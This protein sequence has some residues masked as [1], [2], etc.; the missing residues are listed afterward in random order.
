MVIV[1]SN[2]YT[3]FYKTKL[4]ITNISNSSVSTKELSITQIIIDILLKNKQLHKKDSH[5]IENSSN[6]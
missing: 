6:Y 5:Y 4:N 1:H 3:N 2:L